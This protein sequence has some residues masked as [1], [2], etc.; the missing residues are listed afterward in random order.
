MNKTAKI[1]KCGLCSQSTNPPHT[2]LNCPRKDELPERYEKLASK[3]QS[4]KRSR[5]Q[6]MAESA[7]TARI[8][9]EISSP[10]PAQRGQAEAVISPRLLLSEFPSSPI[11]P[12]LAGSVEPLPFQFPEDETNRQQHHSSQFTES[13]RIELEDLKSL[14]LQRNSYYDDQFSQLKEIILGQRRELEEPKCKMEEQQRELEEQRRISEEQRI[15]LDAY[16]TIS[17]SH[18]ADILSLKRAIVSL[19]YEFPAM[20]FITQDDLLKMSYPEV[21]F[22][23]SDTLR[24]GDICLFLSDQREKKNSRLASF[25]LL[26]KECFNIINTDC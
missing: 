2:Y 12:Y 20:N 23:S 15:R 4:R 9:T 16:D 24:L 6:I 19:C 7:A 26:W 18:E 25:S 3:A 11:A 8:F 10:C 5:S 13:D 14:M 21:V 17:A 1:K 22:E